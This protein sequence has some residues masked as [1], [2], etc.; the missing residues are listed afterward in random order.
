MKISLRRP[1]T[2]MPL[3]R[4]RLMTPDCN[5]KTLL[6]GNPANSLKPLD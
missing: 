2:A 6:T 4:H 5:L 1:L 3:L